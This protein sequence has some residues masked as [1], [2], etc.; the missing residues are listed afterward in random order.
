MTTNPWSGTGRTS[1]CGTQAAASS[2]SCQWATLIPSAAPTRPARKTLQA[3]LH[4]PAIWKV[5]LAFAAAVATP[6]HASQARARQVK[7]HRRHQQTGP[8]PSRHEQDATE[9]VVDVERKGLPTMT[10]AQRRRVVER[11]CHQD[12]PA[13]ILG[14]SQI[15]EVGRYSEACAP[16][17]RV[18]GRSRGKSM[19]NTTDRPARK[20]WPADDMD[21]IAYEGSAERSAKRYGPE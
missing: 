7:R 18:R 12:R 2:T 20:R 17:T 9:P 10:P 19:Q 5:W 13:L 15:H 14:G 6:S 1:R 8:F 16:H 3:R 11:T 21:T 4:G